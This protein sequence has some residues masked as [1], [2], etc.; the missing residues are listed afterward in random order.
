MR[1]ICLLLI[2]F[3]VFLQAQT[4][5]HATAFVGLGNYYGD[6]QDRLFDFRQ[7]SGAFGIGA[8]YDLAEN[9]SVRTGIMYAKIGAD[10]KK[11]RENLRFRNLNFKTRILEWNL[12]GEYSMFN[13]NEERITPYVFA[14]VAVFHFDPY[15]TD[16]NGEK[17]FL[18]P[19]STEGQGLS[20]YPSRKPY[21]LTQFA[22]PF[23]AGIKFRVTDN[24]VLAYE[25]ALRKTFTDY[26][27]DVSTTYVNA[28]ALNAAKGA[29]S[30]ELSYRTDELRGG[31][32]FYPAEGTVRGGPKYKDW[33]YYSGVTVTIGINSGYESGFGLFKRGNKNKLDCPKVE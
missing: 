2:L 30:V 21:K 16:A 5:L 26:L 19:L 3:P 12:T 20:L 11:N 18:Q 6:V 32:Q 7:S 17:F 28:S 33:Y 14:G 25:L 23:G 29:K 8:K 22:I 1:S 15:T 4:R 24:V 9:F 10:D 27:D 31:S 13:I